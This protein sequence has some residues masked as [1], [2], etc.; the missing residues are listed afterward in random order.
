MLAPVLAAF[1]LL[2]SAT[3]SITIDSIAEQWAKRA[4]EIRNGEFEWNCDIIDRVPLEPGPIA[5]IESPLRE[6]A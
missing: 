1:P 5:E 6:A 4:T 2:P 3:P